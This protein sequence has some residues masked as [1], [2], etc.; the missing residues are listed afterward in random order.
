M[1]VNYERYLSSGR[2][3]NS[4]V[5][6]SSYISYIPPNFESQWIPLLSWLRGW[7]SAPGAQSCNHLRLWRATITK[8]L[9]VCHCHVLWSHS[10]IS[11]SWWP[12]EVETTISPSLQMGKLRVQ[13]FAQHASSCNS[14]CEMGHRPRIWAPSCFCTSVHSF[15]VENCLLQSSAEKG[16]CPRVLGSQWQ[17]I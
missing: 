11:S 13:E 12:Y 7:K 6:S 9:C 5:S 4:F 14:N 8:A 15:F 3:Q 16:V 1:S 10:L 2:N 17:S